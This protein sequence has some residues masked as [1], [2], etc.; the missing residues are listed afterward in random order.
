MTDHPGIFQFPWR[1]NGDGIVLR[2]LG[3]AAAMARELVESR[4]CRVHGMVKVAKLF[5]SHRQYK[6]LTTQG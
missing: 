1:S 2:A 5:I 6:G 3:T 4:E